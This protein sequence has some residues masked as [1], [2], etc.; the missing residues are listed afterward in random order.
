[1]SNKET[2]QTASAAGRRVFFFRKNYYVTELCV[3]VVVA[4]AVMGRLYVSG[5]NYSE[6]CFHS[7]CC[8]CYALG[9]HICSV[10]WPRPTFLWALLRVSSSIL[11][12]L[13]LQFHKAL[14]S[15]F[16]V[17]GFKMYKNLKWGCETKAG[18]RS[19]QRQKEQ[20]RRLKRL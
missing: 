6:K 20:K 3:F 15:K 14:L 4:V 18:A 17:G 11:S 12:G 19:K 7:F 2:Q 10:F 8:R 13:V 1:M 5:R 9:I 16:C